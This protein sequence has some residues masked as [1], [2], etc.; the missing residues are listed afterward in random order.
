MNF[1]DAVKLCLTQKYGTFSGRAQRPEFWWYMLFYV[2]VQIVTS[3]IDSVLGLGLINAL[4]GLALLVPTLAVT[5]RR[6]HDL[7]QTGWI[8]IAP[9]IVALILFAF[10][11]VMPALTMVFI[12]LMIAVIVAFYIY[13]A[14]PGQPGP[15][16]YGA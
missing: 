8:Q 2:L 11:F 12:V 15:N 4:A 7:G 1:Q 6:L 16:K 14:M 13:L 10:I 5:A 9:G 3:L